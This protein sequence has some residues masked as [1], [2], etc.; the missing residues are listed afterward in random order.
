MLLF[1]YLTR[2]KLVAT[3]HLAV[4]AAVGLWGGRL[5]G[6][7]VNPESDLTR[8]IIQAGTALVLAAGSHV[9]LDAVPHNDE[10]YKIYGRIPLLAVELPIIFTIIFSI[11]Y[12]RNLNPI[13]IFFGLVGA[14]WSDVFSTFGL[15]TFLHE[16]FH[17]I[18]RVEM[19]GSIIVQLSIAIASLI[20]LF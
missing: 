20:F 1:R 17:S 11:A 16:N 9:I 13:I 10:I 14:A 7:I 3:T 19:V 15:A 2:P 18:H 6:W 4:G 5:A 12:L 8:V